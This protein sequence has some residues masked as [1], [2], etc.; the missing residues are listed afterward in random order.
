MNKF[1]TSSI[2]ILV[3]LFLTQIAS[4]SDDKIVLKLHVLVLDDISV[5]SKVETGLKEVIEFIEKF[6][7]FSI[8][9][10]I[11]ESTLPH[12]YTRYD[13]YLN[14]VYT[15]R[16]CVVV[17]YYNIRKS[18]IDSLPVADFYMLFWNSY[19]NSPLHAGSAWGVTEG[20]PK[21]KIKRPYATIPVDLWWY[22][23]N[24]F[25]GFQQRSAQIITHELVNLLDCLLGVPPY[26]CKRLTCETNIDAY[27]D[28]K[29]RLSKL[30]QNCY[31]KFIE[32]NRKRLN[33]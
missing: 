20:I 25:E 30:T 11:T 21:K 19:N 12:N 13:C 5:Y 6:S 18:V 33:L 26:N 15:K 32:I 7:D 27:H 14:K 4:A 28:E 9:Y 8:K 16:G 1:K 31:R 10:K 22:N 24:P 23:R 17:N 2:L 29:C 3:I